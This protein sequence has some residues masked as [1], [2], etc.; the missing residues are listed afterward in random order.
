LTQAA[1]CDNKMVLINLYVCTTVKGE[2]VEVTS[3][4]V[5]VLSVLKC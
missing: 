1:A 2:M 4:N 5:R 3:F